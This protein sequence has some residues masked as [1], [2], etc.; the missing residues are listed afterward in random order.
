MSE[1]GLL[2]RLRWRIVVVRWHAFAYAP[3]V[4]RRLE[5]PFG[6]QDNIRPFTLQLMTR[7]VVLVLD[8]P[9]VLLVTGGHPTRPMA[10]PANPEQ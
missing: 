3:L 1:G 10:H 2:Q 9:C 4:G 8:V 5:Q 7:Q 6:V